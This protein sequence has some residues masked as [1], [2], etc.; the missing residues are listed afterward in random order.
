M[1]QLKLPISPLHLIMYIVVEIERLIGNKA[2][3][4]NCEI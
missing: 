2:N 3:T 4:C 1:K